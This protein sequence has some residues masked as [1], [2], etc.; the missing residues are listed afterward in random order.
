MEPL[1]GVFVV[2]VVM[3]IVICAFVLMGSVSFILYVIRER[4]KEKGVERTDQ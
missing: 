3:G 1:F 2:V 4:R